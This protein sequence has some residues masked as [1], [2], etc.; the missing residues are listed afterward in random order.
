MQV[1]SFEKAC[2]L[3]GYDAANILPDV[4]KFPSKHQKAIIAF[5]ML[6]IINEAMNEGK[7]LDWNDDDEY[8]Y[9]PWFD[10]EY[11]KKNN[12][13]G[14]RFDVTIYGITATYTGGGSRLCF[15]TREDAK[16]AGEHFVDIY[17]DIC[18]IDK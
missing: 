5:A 17:R 9:Y 7:E 4:T 18:V 2:E 14:F 1:E 13:S 6:V 11:H 16:F 8:K 3:R 10:M 15:F 12:P